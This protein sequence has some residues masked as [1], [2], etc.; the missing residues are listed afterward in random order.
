MIGPSQSNQQ[1][2]ID[3]VVIHTDFCIQKKSASII[4]IQAIISLS[5]ISYLLPTVPHTGLLTAAGEKISSWMAYSSEL[6]S[7]PQNA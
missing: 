6:F 4:F 1:S 7:T 2:S 5:M 3:L